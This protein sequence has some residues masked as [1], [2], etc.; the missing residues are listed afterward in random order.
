MASNTVLI[1]ILLSDIH[2]RYFDF[3][4]MSTLYLDIREQLNFCC[5]SFSVGQ[6]I[7]YFFLVDG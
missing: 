2:M 4:I 1:G 6:M 7:M 3:E 5:K